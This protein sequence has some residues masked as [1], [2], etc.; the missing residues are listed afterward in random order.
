MRFASCDHLR[1]GAVVAHQPH[2]A[3]RG[4]TLAEAEQEVR[5]RAGEG[6]DGLV[7]VADDADLLA[8]AEPLVEQR[9]LQRTDVLVLVDDELVVL[10][11]HRVGHL[12]V[13]G[14]QT[15]GVEQD[16][17]EVDDVALPLDLLVRRE[18][19]D[20]QRGVDAG[21]RHPGRLRGGRRVV[22]AVGHGDLDPLDL[23]AEVADRGAV[24]GQPQPA[25]CLGDQPG[26]VRHELGQVAPDVPRPEP[27]QLSQGC[28]VEG[29]G[30]Y[31]GRAE[32]AQPGAHLAGR[33]GGEGDGEHPL[34][35]VDAA[36]DA[37][38]DAGRDRPGLPGAGSGEHAE[39]ALQRGGDLALLGVEGREQ[40]VGG[41]DGR[42][43][44]ILAAGPDTSRRRCGSRHTGARP[45]SRRHSEALG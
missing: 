6:V 41:G 37:V 7:G 29:A 9:L 25:G 40:L 10:A 3:G 22:V 5:R 42:H 23:G 26:L 17:L 28:G 11:A 31:A 33:P 16:V 30:L 27:A 44:P 15:D 4:V 38:G 8:V 19:P 21:R 43:R 18:Q 1:C 34:R 32:V 12:T 45:G 35:H 24:G 14:D 13:L 20:H 39:R 36:E 2:L